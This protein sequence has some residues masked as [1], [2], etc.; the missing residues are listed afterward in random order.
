MATLTEEQQ[1]MLDALLAEAVTTKDLARVKLYISKGASARAATGNVREIWRAPDPKGRSFGTVLKED[2]VSG[3]VIHL[4]VLVGSQEILGF[5]LEQGADIDAMTD[6]GNTPLKL[7]VLKQDM[8]LA[9][10]LAEKGADPFIKNKNGWSALGYARQQLDSTYDWEIRQKLIDVMVA[11]LPE[12]KPVSAKP[13]EKA[14]IAI[15]Q[16]ME[17]TKPLVFKPKQRKGERFDL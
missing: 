15:S 9:Q 17:A 13:V 1:K 12:A 4:A 16:E 5:L 3:N 8:A 2:T 14:D 10:Y 7:A 6:N 11:A